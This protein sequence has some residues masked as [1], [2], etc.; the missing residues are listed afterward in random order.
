MKKVDLGIFLPIANNGWI[1]ST[2]APKNMP[3]YE[4]IKDVALLAEKTGYDY[5]FSLGVHRGFDGETEFMNHSLDSLSLMTALAVETK[6]VK[7]I[8][9]VKPLFLHPLVLSKMV[10]TIDEISNGRFGMNIVTGYNPFEF[11]QMGLSKEGSEWPST[12]YEYCEE[13]LNVVKLLWSKERVTYKGKYLEVDDAYTVPK[14]VQKPHPS[15][16]CAGISDK[17]MDFT[18]R[19]ANEAFIS[20]RSFDDIKSLSLKVKKAAKKYGRPIKTHAPITII[21]GDT[22]KE[23]QDMVKYFEAAKD[24]TAMENMA[25]AYAPEKGTGKM[26]IDQ[27]KATAFYGCLP[28]VGSPETIAN[29]IEDL[30]VNGDLDGVLF[31]FPEFIKGINDFNDKVVPLLEAKGLRSDLTMASK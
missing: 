15:L 1:I 28:A 16:V 2:N 7:I 5:I 26:I 17:G 6:R 20:G 19:N 31:T 22:D 11:N 29:I 30:A 25:S 12:R 23:A 27:T 21:L 10:A 9:T 13:W 24:I 8:A 14:P 3:T 4:G 18:I